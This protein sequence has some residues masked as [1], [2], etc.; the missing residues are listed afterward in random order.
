M[1]Y[2]ESASLHLQFAQSDRTLVLLRVDDKSNGWE[3]ISLVGK[4][5][6][7]LEPVYFLFGNSKC[8]ITCT[9]SAMHLRNT[10]SEL[11]KFPPF[12]SCSDLFIILTAKEIP[13]IQT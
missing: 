13:Q 12:K 7:S 9:N 5:L 10:S 6:L 4:K 1:P 8:C 2:L 11:Y 3:I